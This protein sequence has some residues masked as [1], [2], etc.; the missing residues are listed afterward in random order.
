MAN[1][2][3][4]S[5]SAGGSHWV[6]VDD[7]EDEERMRKKAEDDGDSEEDEANGSSD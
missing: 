1:R 2:F 7:L 5:L 4:R 3:L 6:T